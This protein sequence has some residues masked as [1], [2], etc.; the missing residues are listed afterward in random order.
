MVWRAVQQSTHQILMMTWRERYDL[1]SDPLVRELLQKAMDP[2]FLKGLTDEEWDFRPSRN[3]RKM[4]R[5]RGKLRTLRAKVV[6]GHNPEN[7]GAFRV[8]GDRVGNTEDVGEGE[9][10]LVFPVDQMKA[11]GPSTM[12]ARRGGLAKNPT[13]KRVSDIEKRWAI[14]IREEG[15]EARIFSAVNR[16]HVLY[17]FRLILET[18]NWSEIDEWC[19][20]HF[21]SQ[22]EAGVAALEEASNECNDRPNAHRTEGRCHHEDVGG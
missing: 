6:E 15:Q 12:R 14:L 3:H 10:L 16:E 7:R 18:D 22:K 9:I 11:R 8:V 21:A 17:D 13:R 2:E 19:E 5:R 20:R 4:A 1:V